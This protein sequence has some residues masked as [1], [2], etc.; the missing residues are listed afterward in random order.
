MVVF[1]Q[2]GLLCS[3]WGHEAFGVLNKTAK[4]RGHLLVRFDCQAL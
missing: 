2:K 3:S 1:V 4:V